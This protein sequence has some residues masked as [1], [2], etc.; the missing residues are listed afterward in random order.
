MGRGSISGLALPMEMT[1]HE[2]CLVE[3]HRHQWTDRFPARS[4]SREASLK[5][6]VRVRHEGKLKREA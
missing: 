2:A 6:G 5:T 1:G 4:P 3:G